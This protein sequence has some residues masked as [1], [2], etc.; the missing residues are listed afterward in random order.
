LAQAVLAPAH[1]GKEP[2][3]MQHAEMPVTPLGRCM[4]RYIPC[5]SAAI[6]TSSTAAASNQLLP[7]TKQQTMIG[8]SVACK[9]GAERGSVS[10]PL[11]TSLNAGASSRLRAESKHQIASGHSLV[12]EQGA[13]IAS[14]SS[15]V[16]VKRY[17]SKDP[18]TGRV[19]GMPCAF[20]GGQCLE[21]PNKAAPPSDRCEACQLRHCEV[22]H[23]PMPPASLQQLRCACEALVAKL[24]EGRRKD[25]LQRLERLYSKLETGKIPPQVQHQLSELMSAVSADSHREAGRLC[26]TLVAQQWDEHKD[27]L[28]A[29]RSLLSK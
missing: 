20:G 19:W 17:E 8:R 25:V 5:T 4:W 21:C 1:S 28:I 18:V 11:E 3:A 12:H 10:S 14:L 15:P 24:T 23:A 22:V 6:E 9:Q 26:T 29:L 27:W 7:E 16:E 2:C 13:D